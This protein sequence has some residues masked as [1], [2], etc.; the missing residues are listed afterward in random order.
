MLDEK[1][2]ENN[3]W[4]EEGLLIRVYSLHKT[5]GLHGVLHRTHQVR[6]TWVLRHIVQLDVES[7]CYR[8]SHALL[9]KIMHNEQKSAS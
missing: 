9:D 4:L 1:K 5:H 3:K 2:N 6:A 8:N 7:I